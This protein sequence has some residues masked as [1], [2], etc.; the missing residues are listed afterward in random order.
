M[1]TSMLLVVL[2]VSLLQSI[3]QAQERSF[4]GGAVDI[5][6]PDG[7]IPDCDRTFSIKRYRV[8]VAEQIRRVWKSLP[9]KRVVLLLSISR[10]GIPKTAE[11]LEGTG[12]RRTDKY[13]L[14]KVLSLRFPEIYLPA[15]ENL[16]FKLKLDG[17]HSTGSCRR[18]HGN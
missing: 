3:V 8:T 18:T 1:K 17:N 4:S 6:N 11:F 12:S 9:K 13:L 10:D 7:S 15:T 2:T 14:D 16:Q 5:G